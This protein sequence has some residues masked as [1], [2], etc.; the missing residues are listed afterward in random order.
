MVDYYEII[1]SDRNFQKI[2]LK[3][4]TRN[5]KWKINW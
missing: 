2:E 3:M 4:L 1:K 5:L